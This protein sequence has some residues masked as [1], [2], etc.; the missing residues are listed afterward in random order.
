MDLDFRGALR[1]I[2]HLIDETPLLETDVPG[3]YLKCEHDQVTGSFKVRGA[4]NKVMSLPEGAIARGLVAASAGNHGLGVAY[5]AKQVGASAL[6]VVPD[7]AVQPK[8]DG[9]RALGGEVVQVPG[10]FGAAEA[11]GK[12][13]AEKRDAVWVSPYNDRDIIEGQGTLGLELARQLE[14]RGGQ[15]VSWEVYI[16]VSGGGLVCGVGLAL[17][18]EGAYRVIGVQTQA[19]PYMATFVAGGDLAVIV[20]TPTLADGLA[21][22]V[23]RG[24]MTFDLIGDAVDEMQ[25]V[26]EQEIKQSMMKAWRLFGVEIEPSAAVPLAAALR[27]A[28]NVLRVVV[29]SGGNVSPDLKREMRAESGAAGL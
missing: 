20:E 11:C 28:G 13:L 17:K 7:D 18:D 3:L 8:V 10:G 12:S 27:A 1:R 21:G 25:L 22:P 24:S 9:I 14:A 2:G 5:A 16:P 6:I 23:E 19:A 4:L 29:L 15:G 26:G